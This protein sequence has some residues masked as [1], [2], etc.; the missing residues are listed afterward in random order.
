LIRIIEGLMRRRGRFDA[1]IVETTGLADPRPSR[2]PFSS[3]PT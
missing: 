3:T 2:K 1:I